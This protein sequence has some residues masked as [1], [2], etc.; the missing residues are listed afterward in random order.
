[1]NI[2]NYYVEKIIEPYIS[3][4]KYD[5]LNIIGYLTYNGI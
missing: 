2:D 5:E 4:I 1:M 3:V